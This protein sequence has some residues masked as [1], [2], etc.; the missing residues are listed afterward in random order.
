MGSAETIG[1]RGAWREVN[2][3]EEEEVN[4]E[5][6]EAMEIFT[7]KRS[8]GK[9]KSGEALIQQ[10]TLNKQKEQKGKLMNWSRQRSM[11]FLSTLSLGE[12]AD[13]HTLRETREH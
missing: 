3:E 4:E 5:E 1:F 6:R 9:P 12:E 10:E 2:A 11:E 8:R 13:R 7:D